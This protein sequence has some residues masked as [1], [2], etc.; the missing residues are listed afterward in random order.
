MGEISV[1]DDFKCEWISYFRVTSECSNSNNRMRVDCE[2]IVL[3]TKG[4]KS[5]RLYSHTNTH[6]QSK[7]LWN[8]MW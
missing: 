5:T 3:Y 2:S 7:R 4:Q 8:L 6:A 1:S